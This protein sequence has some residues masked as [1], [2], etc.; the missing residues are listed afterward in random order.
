MKVLLDT[1]V[2]WPYMARGPLRPG[3]K[4]FLDSTVTEFLL[5]PLSVWEIERKIAL[6][7]AVPPLDAHW[8]EGVTRGFRWV[9]LGVE[10]AR[11]AAGWS[12]AH[13]DPVDRMLAAIAK[14]EN[15]TLVHTDTKLRALSGFPQRYFQAADFPNS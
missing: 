5:C 11:L 15:V 7:K 13:K 1:S 3:L 6:G 8:R 14:V 9:H 4:N 10:S 2:W 12:W